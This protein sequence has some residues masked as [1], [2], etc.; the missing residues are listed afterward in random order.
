MTPEVTLALQLVILAA[1][2][3]LTVHAA[4]SARRAA[5][6][7]VT[8][9]F[10]ALATAV[11]RLQAVTRSEKMSKVRQAALVPAEQAQPVSHGPLSHE[12]LRA[13]ARARHNG[14]TQ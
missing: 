6:F 2:G 8:R 9:D 11:S 12:Q 5:S 14:A 7:D 4:L 10:D 13:L 1:T 3:F